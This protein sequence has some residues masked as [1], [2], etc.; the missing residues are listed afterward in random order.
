MRQ[1]GSGI[2]LSFYPVWLSQL[3]ITASDIGFMVGCSHIVSASTSL[4]VGYLTRF[5]REHWLLIV[6]IGL[7][8]ATIAVTPLLGAG[9]IE[10]P[11]VGKIYVLLFG[12]ICLRG[13]SQGLNMPLMMSIGMQAVSGGE[14][15][16]I[17]ALR[18]T[19]NRA[20]SAL[21]PLLM[22][23]IAQWFSLE[24]AFYIVG[25]LGLTGLAFTARWASRS[26]AF[27]KNL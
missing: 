1:T 5:M 19:T 17:V 25:A 21:V 11:G 13:L 16:K 18:I 12:M 10:L 2:Q 3:G 24:A 27:D 23:V 6:T 26:P 9:Y 22:G 7:S 20:T 15:G 14:Q 4:S 8:I